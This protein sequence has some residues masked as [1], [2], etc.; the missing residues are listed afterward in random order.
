M[1]LVLVLSM[2]TGLTGCTTFNNFKN[3]FFSE[4]QI[5]KEKTIKIGIYEPLTGEDKTQ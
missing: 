1:C 4:N 2:V 3:A 5:A